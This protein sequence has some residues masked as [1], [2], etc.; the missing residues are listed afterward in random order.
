VRVLASILVTAALAC[1]SNSNPAPTPPA[2]PPSTPT[3]T[4]PPPEVAS[5]SAPVASAPQPPPPPPT[6]ATP[7]A[8][9]KEGGYDFLAEA[10][11]LYRVAGCGSTDPLPAELSAD[12]AVVDRHC[13]SLAPD[14]KK[15][16]EKYYVTARAWFDEHMPKDLP[17]T[18]V[19]A[20]G[21][22]DLLSALTAF[23]DASEITT[24]S[25]ELAGDPRKLPSLKPAE[26]EQQLAAFR[27]Q[28]GWLV[29]V[30][31][32]T[33]E[34]LSK[35]QRNDLPGQV[36]S[37]LLGM[38][39]LGYEPLSMKYFSID[40]NGNVHYLEK[41]EIESDTKATK[42]LRES[43]NRPAFAA[44]FRNVEFRY[45]KI[46]ETAVHVHRHIAW[47]LDDKG[48]AKEP[49]LIKHLEAKGKTTM[50]VKGASYLLW[51]SD[52][53]RMRKY[54][55]D[56]MVWM[57]SDST[58]IPPNLAPGMVQEPFGRFQT[59][60]LEGVQNTR[61]AVAMRNLWKTAK[62]LPFRYGYVD[63]DGGSHLMFTHPK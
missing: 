60:F 40:D 7:P 12:Q 29:L 30:G 25:L 6:P 20:F 35:G 42:Q 45:R 50:L 55:L 57:L 21:G 18:V 52:F 9:P 23:P 24:I 14:M 54:L 19:Y 27:A 33:S 53:G 47:N 56:N 49:Q 43:W 13:K 4:P 22:G 1:S 41:D 17:K 34:N 26:L 48:L 31:S 58:G 16:R 39:T 51:T 5:G 32:N 62:P 10:K 44:A 46:G 59:P 3:A 28:I 37:F 11:L 36:M 2:T 61:E 63:K 8:V 38:A 15:Y